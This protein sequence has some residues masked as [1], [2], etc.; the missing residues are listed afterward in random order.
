MP[1]GNLVIAIT[2]SDWLKLGQ[3]MMLLVV[4]LYVLWLMAQSVFCPVPETL[5]S[6]Y[7][8]PTAV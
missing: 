2:L 3:K 1:G 7:G 6:A 5:A 4:L 8:L